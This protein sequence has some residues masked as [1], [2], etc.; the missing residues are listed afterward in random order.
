MVTGSAV[1]NFVPTE[2]AT[3]PS[4]TE[5]DRHAER[6]QHQSPMGRPPAT[7][8]A[9]P[10]TDPTERS[11]PPLRMTK[12]IPTATTRWSTGMGPPSRGASS[13]AGRTWSATR[14]WAA[15]SITRHLTR[16][17]SYQLQERTAEPAPQYN[18]PIHAKRKVA[19]SADISHQSRRR[20]R[21][22]AHDP[23]GEE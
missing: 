19:A 18:P 20:H 2:A 8:P 13:G 16:K 10:A 1:E 3:S 7:T 21:S 23:E 15:P 6:V 11:I 4:P 14:A 22:H 9:S 17:V 12:I 5:T